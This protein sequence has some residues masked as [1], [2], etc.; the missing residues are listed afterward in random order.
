MPSG[1][2]SKWGPWRTG[3]ALDALAAEMSK[4]WPKRARPD[5]SIADH[6]HTPPSDHIPN[7]SDVVLALDISTGGISVPTLVNVLRADPYKRVHYII[8]QDKFYDRDLGFKPVKYHGDYHSHVHVSFYGGSRG[9]DARPFG[10]LAPPPKPAPPKA[11]VYPLPAGHVYG[12]ITGP[13]W[14][15]GGWHE[16]ERGAVLRVQQQ[17]IRRRAVPGI[18]NPADPWA[19]GRYEQ[20]TVDAVKRFQRSR[21]DTSPDGLVGPTTWR[22]LFG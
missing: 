3:R 8:F 13:E 15:H 22:W 21:G 14:Q 18:T 20:A 17:L 19:D 4:K 11:P 2:D 16:K 9:D 1:V 6:A 10:L 7:G 12:P 5:G